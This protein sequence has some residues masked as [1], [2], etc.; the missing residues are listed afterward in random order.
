MA[1]R[2]SVK[3]D[4]DFTDDIAPGLVAVIVSDMLDAEEVDHTDV[5]VMELDEVTGEDASGWLGVEDFS[6][7]DDD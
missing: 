6:P 5:K 1:R 2:F 7:E 3:F 4:L